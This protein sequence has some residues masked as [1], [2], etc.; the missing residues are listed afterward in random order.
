MTIGNSS[1]NSSGG[2]SQVDTQG[3]YIVATVAD[4]ATVPS[5][6]Q[7]VFVA[8]T[9]RGGMFSYSNTGIVDNGTVFAGATGYWVRDNVAHYE[10][11]WFGAQGNYNWDLKTGTDDTAVFLACMAI[12]HVTWLLRSNRMYL[13]NNTELKLIEGVG[14]LGPKNSR[15]VFK[16]DCSVVANQTKNC[17]W[18]GAKTRAAGFD[19]HVSAGN[20]VYEVNTAVSNTSGGVCTVTFAT[21]T[22]A[23]TN[24]VVGSKVELLGSVVSV[25]GVNRDILDGTYTVT[26]VTSTTIT[27]NTGINV[28]Y[29]ATVFGRTISNT[30]R[31]FGSALYINSEWNE[32]TRG[33]GATLSGGYDGRPLWLPWSHWFG[34]R[35]QKVD[36]ITVSTS[37]YSAFTNTCV[38]GGSVAKV[39]ATGKGYDPWGFSFNN[40]RVH[41]EWYRGGYLHV[42]QQYADTDSRLTGGTNKGTWNATTNIPAISS[43]IG[44]LGDYYKV[45]TAGQT[46]IDGN[47]FWPANYYIYFNGTKWIYFGDTVAPWITTAIFND[48]QMEDVLFGFV[49]EATNP[50]G[51][52][53]NAPQGCG[54]LLNNCSHQS[55]TYT[56]RFASIRGMAALTLDECLPWDWNAPIS[57]KYY[58]YE[59]VGTSVGYPSIDIRN[60]Q[61]S[62]WIE[63]KNLDYT[64]PENS[65]VAGL[66]P[67]LLLTL[68]NTGIAAFDGLHFYIKPSG[69]NGKM[70]YRDMYMLPEGEYALD[71]T[72]IAPMRLS[73]T[74]SDFI[75]SGFLEVKTGTQGRRLFTVTGDSFSSSGSL[76]SKN[77]LDFTGACTV[78]VSTAVMG[79]AIADTEIP[80][81]F[82]RNSVGHN[83]NDLKAAN[84]D[85]RSM[86]PWLGYQFMSKVSPNKPLWF[87]GSDYR[88]FDGNY[89]T[90]KDVFATTD[91]LGA[92]SRASGTA[93][94]LQGYAGSLYVACTHS[95]SNYNVTV[96]DTSGF[97]VGSPI[98]L[99]TS[100]A[101]AGSTIASITNATTFVLAPLPDIA[102]TSVVGAANTGVVTATFAA[103]T[104]I[105][106]KVNSSITVSG[107]TPASMNGTFIVTGCT[108][109]SVTWN[110]GNDVAT[111]ATVQGTISFVRTSGTADTSFDQA[112][113]KKLTTSS[114]SPIVTVTS[115]ADLKVGASVNA[116]T[117]SFP[118]GTTISS[119]QS[120]TQYTMSANSLATATNEVTLFNQSVVA[121]LV[122]GYNPA[123]KERIIVKNQI[124]LGGIAMAS[125]DLYN[126]L[127]MVTQ[128]GTTKI[129]WVLTRDV[130]MQVDASPFT[131]LIQCTKGTVNKGIT[132]KPK[133]ITGS[134]LNSGG[135]SQMPWEILGDV[136]YDMT[137]ATVT[138]TT[139]VQVAITSH[140]TMKVTLQVSDD[141]GNYSSIDIV[142]VHNG[143]T[144]STA[145]SNAVTI[146][147][148]IYTYIVDISGSNMRLRVTSSSAA[149]TYYKY[150]MNTIRI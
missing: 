44:T 13:L 85:R 109:T 55:G 69:V 113:P 37:V 14:I 76:A 20:G 65:D 45:S 100:Y 58:P 71:S 2:N 144:V 131:A 9:P 94:T 108:T 116:T 88:F 35:D 54:G 133:W 136:K 87:D 117:T 57:S 29:T 16:Q 91:D 67:K 73:S 46:N 148:A 142:A 114:G 33:D 26:D 32:Y 139:L 132:F 30:N 147:S 59:L 23:T 111:T 127:Y 48:W 134:S 52:V 18:L 56:M 53:T 8:E 36:D 140:R 101:P 19:L 119:I 17:I 149:N 145:T 96:P 5:S 122:D 130:T 64:M 68:D 50:G 129:P 86:T 95:S 63:R 7:R 11:E 125:K 146:G 66:R 102:T 123:Y 110:G 103:Q 22:H 49:A 43:G 143:T 47:M 93:S 78:S 79:A 92:S 137:L 98:L 41:G 80:Y 84:N 75:G 82:W 72:I 106:Y 27:F 60:P 61:A 25:S 135:T 138:Q 12:P 141:S 97:I 90:I 38:S 118:S 81:N 128:V 39:H 115:T 124:N 3:A 70:T 31:Y 105:P 112:I 104:Y 107:L 62:Y 77:A 120:A 21:D 28:A 126:G 99:A 24:F 4:L 34:G 51:A 74:Y 40:V 6:V 121:L 1:S 10:F 42:E 83:P 89:E 15:L 150:S